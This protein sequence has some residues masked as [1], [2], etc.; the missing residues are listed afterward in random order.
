MNIPEE[1]DPD[2]QAGLA[3]FLAT[4]DKTTA[5]VV[6]IDP[7]CEPHFMTLDFSDGE[8]LAFNAGDGD[9]RFA[10]AIFLA[11]AARCGRLA[12]PRH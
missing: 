7:D 5:D 11:I 9:P 10:E 1:L 2:L 4:L 6:A 12:V 3:G 8:C